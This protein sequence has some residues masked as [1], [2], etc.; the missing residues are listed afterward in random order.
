ML[1]TGD[2]FSTTIEFTIYAVNQMSQAA[3]PGW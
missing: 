2:N 3:H 1:A